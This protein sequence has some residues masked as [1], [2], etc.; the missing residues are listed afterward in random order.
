MEKTKKVFLIAAITLVIDQVLKLVVKCNILM[1]STVT[2]IPHF[3][4]L[5]YVENEGAAWSI[6]EGK[7]VFLVIISFLSLLFIFRCLKTDKRKTKI[8]V[9][10]YGLM[11][12]GIIGNMLDRIFY[13]KVIDF[14]SFKIFHHYFPVFNCADMAIVIGMFLFIIDVI[15]EGNEKTI[16]DEQYEKIREISNGK[17]SSRRRKH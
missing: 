10:A 4:S 16:M 6:L 13:Q 5:T 17:N 8:N 7:S 2:I 9:L 1:S 3:F 15:L 14:L 11:I 12:G